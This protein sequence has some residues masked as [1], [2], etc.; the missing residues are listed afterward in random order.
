MSEGK[1]RNKKAIIITGVVMLLGVLMVLAGIFGGSI[2]G[3]FVKDI[4][5]LN[6]NPEDLGKSI[7]TDITVYYDNIDLQD[8]T[9]QVVG[10]INSDDYRFILFDLSALS[11]EEQRNYYS[12]IGQHI[13]ISFNLLTSFQ[14]YA[15]N[16]I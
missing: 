11:E 13:T 16:P 8:K 10:D 2:A 12:G 4:D 5:F 9:L 7:E 1:K 6:I 14:R 15:F 3:L